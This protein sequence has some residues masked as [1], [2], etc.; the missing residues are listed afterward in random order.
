MPLKIT[1]EDNRGGKVKSYRNLGRFG[2]LL[3]LAL[4]ACEVLI[5]IRPFAGFFYASVHFEP[6][7]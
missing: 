5:M 1:D 3:V 4:G 6:L 7:L 2:A